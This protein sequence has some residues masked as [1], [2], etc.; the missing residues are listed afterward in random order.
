[1]QRAGQRWPNGAGESYNGNVA[2]AHE[3]SG[4][5][6]GCVGGMRHT[7]ARAECFEYALVVVIQQKRML[8]QALGRRT[9][10]SLP[11]WLWRIGHLPDILG[12]AA[13]QSRVGMQALVAPPQLLEAAG[14]A[15]NGRTGRALAC[16][17]QPTSPR[18]RGETPASL[19]PMDE[20]R[21]HH[22][23]LSVE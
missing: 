16:F 15:V 20:V 21:R 2:F 14:V 18:A 22:Y 9:F 10:A 3:G 4:R 6:R 5:S 19:A 1:M 17:L 12:A 13:E 8:L 7:K 23:V 11:F